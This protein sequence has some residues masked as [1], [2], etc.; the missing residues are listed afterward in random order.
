M[1]FT[2]TLVTSKIW[3]IK[4]IIIRGNIDPWKI[5]F[6]LQIGLEIDLFPN[7]SILSILI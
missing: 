4:E 6:S 7:S 2:I 1:H 3:M 5:K